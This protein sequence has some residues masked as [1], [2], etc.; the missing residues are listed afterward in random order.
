[1]NRLE[2]VLVNEPTTRIVYLD[3]TALPD[4]A[5]RWVDRH[6]EMG[7][8]VGLG[9]RSVFADELEAKSKEVIDRVAWWVVAGMVVGSPVMYVTVSL[10]AVAIP[11]I[12]FGAVGAYR[13]RALS[14][15]ATSERLRPNTEIDRASVSIPIDV[16]TLH[17]Q[18]GSPAAQH[19]KEAGQ[20]SDRVPAID[21]QL[22]RAVD[23][24]RQI[25]ETSA[26]SSPLLATHRIRL[27]P[28]DERNQIIEHALAL[29]VASIRLGSCPQGDT[30]LAST[31]RRAFSA[32][33]LTLEAGMSR[34]VERVDALE[35]YCG[36]LDE[37]DRE[38]GHAN[39]ARRA[40]DL[41]KELG[42]LFMNAVGDELASEHI[43][44]MQTEASAVTDALE[45]V[46]SS[47]HGSLDTLVA[48]SPRI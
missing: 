22:A 6:R 21:Y 1:M 5:R 41:D 33:D 46:L 30:T 39:T 45:S 24:T 18:V 28:E 17:T 47:A 12:I 48:F 16:F 34:L 27:D 3:E 37:V 32:T 26:W 14:R 36:C 44:N 11:A 8:S 15:L 38:I 40:V 2:W 25:T 42:S 10:W 7:G 4:H 35:G 23:L 13:N 20:G 19:V 31:A 29:R 43:R 9:R